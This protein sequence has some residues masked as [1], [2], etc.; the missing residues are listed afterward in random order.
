M[1]TVM[2]GLARRGRYARNSIVTPTHAHAIMTSGIV[3]KN[4]S[5]LP[6]FGSA[7]PKSGAIQFTRPIPNIAPTI[8]TSPCAKL[9]IRSTP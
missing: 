5:T 1:S 4:V 9:I 6:V 2:R 8:A 7:T 3:S